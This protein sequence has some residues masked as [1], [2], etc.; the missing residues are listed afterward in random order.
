MMLHV[1]MDNKDTNP[2][3]YL[4]SSIALD[5]VHVSKFRQEWVSSTHSLV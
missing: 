1:N 2:T 4:D 5:S 3:F